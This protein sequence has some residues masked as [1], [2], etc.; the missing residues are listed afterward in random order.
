MADGPL[1]REQ[2]ADRLAEAAELLEMQGADRFRVRAYRLGADTIRQLDEDPAAILEREGIEGLVALPTIGDRL[3]RAIDE[4]CTTGRWIQLER[5][6]GET[7]PE[8]LFRTVPGIGAKTAQAI[9]DAL[10]IDS[11]EALEIAA[12]DGSLEDVPGIGPRK[13]ASIRAWLGRS[14]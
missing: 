12:H 4:M 9:H 8:R 2:V 10:H 7:E 5:L 3:A 1:S 13:A 11:L 6:R 14:S